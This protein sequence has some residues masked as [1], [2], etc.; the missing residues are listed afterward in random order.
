[1]S[2][3]FQGATSFNGDISKWHA[4]NVVNMENM[5]RNAR[6][7]EQNL[8]GV[9][10]VNSKAIKT[11]M[12]EGSFGSISRT[13]CTSSS[14]NAASK[15]M[16]STSTRPGLEIVSKQHLKS[17]IA[18]YLIRSSEGHCNDCPQGAIGE[19]DVSRVTDMSKLFFSAISFNDDISKW[20]VS[21]VTNMNRMF[22]GAKSFD[23]DLSNW[24]VS[25]VTD[26]SNMFSGAKS[27]KGETSKSDVSK[28]QS[29]MPKAQEAPPFDGKYSAI[30]ISE[31]G[32]TLSKSSIARERPSIQTRSL[33]QSRGHIQTHSLG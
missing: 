1:M 13:V 2:G 23:C 7:F 19:W 20:D 17:E 29:T 15:K 27:F 32:V 21:R 9:Y 16:P 33:S 14:N 22:M 8:C 3:M 12:F 24:D 11:G 5:F 18:D 25:R 26:A 4:S 28:V 10:W 30:D 6:S 31:V